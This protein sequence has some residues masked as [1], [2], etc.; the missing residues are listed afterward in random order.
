MII[1]KNTLKTGRRYLVLALVAMMTLASCTKLEDTAPLRK[2]TFEKAIYRPQ[3]K[4]DPVT[5]PI[6]DEFTSFKCKAF[7]HAEGYDA[8]QNMFGEGGETISAYTSGHA[9]TTNA[10]EVAYWAPSHDYY[11]PKGESSYINFVGWYDKR[12]IAP[13]EATETSLKWNG[14]TVATTDNLLFADEAWR[15]KANPDANKYGYNGIEK[16]VPM[17]FHHALAQL[18]IEAKVTETTLPNVTGG[19]G[20]GNTYWEVTLSDIHLAGVYN[21]G[22]LVL[23]NA[24]PDGTGSA[25]KEWS[26]S[27]TSTGSTTTINMVAISTPLDKTDATTVLAMQ[28]VLPQTVTNDIVLSFD[29]NIDTYFNT[30]RYAQ[31]KIHASIKLNDVNAVTGPI[32]SWEMNKK[33]T[34]TITIN[35]VTTTIKIDPAMVDWVTETGGSASL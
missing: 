33:I 34:Y 29:Y 8:A 31:E 24:A 20:L 12:G 30:T 4:A 15:Y 2:I 17:L 10:S 18:C 22:N 28:S 35:P 7:L 3:T 1:V 11:W 25:T 26:G 9:I 5:K 13:T 27:W 21:T 32:S 6:T 19:N 23:T 16:G 14:Y